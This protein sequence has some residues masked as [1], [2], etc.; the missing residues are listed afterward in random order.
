MPGTDVAYGGTRRAGSGR[1]A[2]R[3]LEDGH[4]L[5]EYNIQKPVCIPGLPLRTPGSAPAHLCACLCTPLYLLPHR[6]VPTPVPPYGA[7]RC[8]H[9]CLPLHT[10]VHTHTMCTHSALR[11]GVHTGLFLSRS[12]SLALPLPPLPLPLPL[13]LLLPLPLPSLSLSLPLSLSR[14]PSLAGRAAGVCVGAG[15]V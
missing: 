6:R 8:T 2:G 13:P 5:R 3:E 7:C 1:A 15:S 9:V 14:S 4:T 11:Q 12:L 10:P